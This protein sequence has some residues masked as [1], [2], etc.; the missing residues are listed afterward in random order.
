MSWGSQKNK[1][2]KNIHWAPKFQ[3]MFSYTTAHEIRLFPWGYVHEKCFRRMYYYY[4]Y[5]LH[6]IIFLLP[7]LY[8]PNALMRESI[9][10]RINQWWWS[11]IVIKLV[12]LI[13]NNNNIPTIYWVP[14]R[15]KHWG[16]A[17]FTHSQFMCRIILWKRQHHPLLQVGKLRLKAGKHLNQRH[18]VKEW[19]SKDS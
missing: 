17:L 6:Y 13:I 14:T 11:S 9:N 12:L 15:A 3:T 1:K 2:I 5:C 4:L 10:R 19:L 16:Q 18:T 7:L 8:I